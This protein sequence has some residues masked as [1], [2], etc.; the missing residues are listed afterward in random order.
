MFRRMKVSKRGFSLLETML[1]VAILLIVTLMVYEGF[2]STLNYAGDTALAERVGNEQAGKVYAEL[3]SKTNGNL[4]KHVANSET[5][6]IM[7]KGTGVKSVLQVEELDHTTGMSVFS[8]GSSF[9]DGT[10]FTGTTN[11]HGFVYSQ[12]TC[13]NHPN[14]TVQYYKTTISG[15][16][17]IVA[18]CSTTGCS[19]ATGG[20]NQNK[21]VV[22]WGSDDT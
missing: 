22:S 20:T 6:C 4:P 19:Y 15:N 17:A 5:S 12:R 21:L 8:A 18:R 14:A 9:T 13:P 10:T 1:S 11:R 16:T 2:M 3:G 7:I